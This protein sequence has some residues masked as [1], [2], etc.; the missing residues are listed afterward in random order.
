MVCYPHDAEEHQENYNDDS[1]TDAEILTIK[2]SI[3]I[4]KEYLGLE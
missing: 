2:N 3:E 1:V 4:I